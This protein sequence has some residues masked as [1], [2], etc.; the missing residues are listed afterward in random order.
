MGIIKPNAQK[1]AKKKI[2]MIGVVLAILASLFAYGC[3]KD[4]RIE[5]LSKMVLA[6][7]DLPGDYT[8]EYEHTETDFG[9]D[10]LAGVEIE[11]K[12]GFDRTHGEYQVT[13]L[14][15]PHIGEYS[16]ATMWEHKY[17]EESFLLLSFSKNDKWVKLKVWGA[18]YEFLK[19]LAQKA[20]K[21]VK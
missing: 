16:S 20:E 6:E 14:T 3:S 5:E 17:E 13:E 18:D 4:E 9:E 1:L 7:T 2:L 15:D 11:Y 8:L 12:V 21:K 10:N 19:Q